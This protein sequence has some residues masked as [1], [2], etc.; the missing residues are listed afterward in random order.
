MGRTTD[1]TDTGPV[2]ASHVPVMVAEVAEWLRPRPGA[3]LVDATVGPGGHA[4]ALL[5]AA[6]VRLLGLYRDPRALALARSRLAPA[7]DRVVLRQAS[8]AELPAL[9]DELGWDGADGVLLDLGASSLQLDDPGRGFSFRGAAP[10]D[11]RMDPAAPLTADE[12]VNRWPEEDLARVLATYGEERRAR[13]VARAVTRAR[14]LATTADLV[15]VV[16]GVLGAGG[17][18]IHPATR[19]F[20]A[21]RIAVNDEL[22][23][24]DRFLAAGWTTL[25]PGGRLVVIAYHSLE[26]RRVK[27]AF[28][29]WAADC[30]CPPRIPE[31]R[32]GWSAKVRLLVRRPLGPSPAEVARNPRARS[33]RL[34]VVE[35]LGSPT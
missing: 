8:Y 34:R 22:G 18:G 16:Q 20:Q 1:E 27:E 3:C 28:R 25:R 35:R 11:M 33:A 7:A 14:P 15:R 21:L 4:A 12:I 31:C 24:L 30:L 29:R 13:A 5:A 23:H 9:L 17:R 26:D 10:L 6:P 19:T 2:G 32:C